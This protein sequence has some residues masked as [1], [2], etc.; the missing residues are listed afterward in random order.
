MK[1]KIPIPVAI[2]ER[3]NLPSASGMERLYLCR[4]SFNLESKLTDIADKTF[5]DSGTRVHNALAGISEADLLNEDERWVYDRC[6]EHEVSLVESVFGVER[7]ERLE[8]WREKRQWLY[9]EDDEKQSSG[10]LDVVYFDTDTLEALVIDYKSGYK[11]V[12]EPDRNIQLREYAVLT[13]EKYNASKVTVAVIQPRCS[14]ATAQAIYEKEDLEYAGKELR[15]VLS[16]AKDPNAPRVPGAAQ[17]EY[18]KAKGIC[19]ELKKQMK[20]EIVH[21]KGITFLSGKE[22]DYREEFMPG[23]VLS[24]ILDKVAHVERA[25]KAVREEAKIRIKHGRDVPGYS[26]VK[27]RMQ[28]MITNPY[29]MYEKI[30]NKLQWMSPKD[31]WNTYVKISIGDID[32]LVKKHPPKSLKIKAEVLY[33]KRF[34]EFIESKSTDLVLERTSYRPLVAEAKSGKIE[35][36][37]Q[38]K[39]KDIPRNQSLEV[40]FGKKEHVKKERKIRVNR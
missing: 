35:A 8:I 15:V 30:V 27:G 3:E 17:C 29:A 36:K 38:E 31:F 7:I 25:C 6:T 5:A 37:T 14:P 28:R 4:G 2:D 20:S 34:G 13:A 24:E 26:L 33:A 21:V 16:E 18:C 39:L 32:K 23:Y 22:L 10:E 40:L 11:P 9:S 12:T 19:P 1:K